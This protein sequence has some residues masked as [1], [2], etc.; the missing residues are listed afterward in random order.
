MWFAI[1][2]QQLVCWLNTDCPRFGHGALAPFSP[3]TKTIASKQQLGVLLAIAVKISKCCCLPTTGLECILAHYG[4]KNFLR[5]NKTY[6]VTIIYD[7]IITY[8][9]YHVII[10]ISCY[11]VG[12]SANRRSMDVIFLV[13]T[14]WHAVIEDHSR[15]CSADLMSSQRMMA[16]LTAPHH[17]F[18][19]K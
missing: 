10:N 11:M 17:T 8:I 5:S 3:I 2:Y 12:E 14:A 7:V 15:K 9:T 18:I 1:F 16:S 6:H 4:F 19:S 13:M